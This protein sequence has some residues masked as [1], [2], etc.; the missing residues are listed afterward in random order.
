MALG[1]S[2]ASGT[3]SFAA[4]IGNNT[5]SYG[6]IGDYSVA[7]GK[8][9]KAS[10]T[11]SV[12]LGD[13][14]NAT[15]TYSSIVGYASTASANYASVFGGRS[16]TASAT[17]ATVIG[18]YANT[19]SGNGSIAT[20]FANTASGA[21]A[22][23]GGYGCT[24]SNA[25]AFAFG[26]TS[27]ASGANS[28]SIG[29][30]STAS[31]DKAITIGDNV[32][33]TATNQINLG[34]TADTVR[35][36]EGYTLPTA[37]GSANQVLQTNGSGALSFAD[38]GGGGFDSDIT[39]DGKT[40]NYTIVAGDAGKIISHSSNDVTFTFTAAATLGAGWHCWVKNR[41]GAADVTT[42]DFN[43]SE[44]LDG[45][46]NGKLFTGESIHVYCDGSNFHSVDRTI[47]WAGNTATDYYAQP[48][49][50]GGG[51]IAAGLQ[52]VSGGDDSIAIG[53]SSTANSSYSTAIGYGSY[54]S[55]TRAMA[56]G[57]SRTGG[58]DSLSA[59]IGTNSSSYGA[60]GTGAIAMGYQAKATTQNSIA[61]GA[62]TQASGFDNSICIGWQSTATSSRGAAVIGGR[63]NNSTG[64]YSTVLGGQGNT[65]SGD[66]S[67][68]MGDGSTASHNNSVSI[69]DSVQSTAVNQIN[70][71]GT[72]DTV[73]ISE[74]YTL[75]TA[76]GSANQVLT[77]NGSGVVS[78]AA[79]GGGA[80]LYAANESSPSAQPSATG[81]N[82]V[83]IGD[84]SVS[85][86]AD[87]LAFGDGATA[88][89]TRSTAIG[90]NATSSSINST[91][92]GPNATSSNFYTV[93]IGSPSNGTGSVATG[94]F[95]AIAI[96][97]YA[98]GTD[99]LA[100]AIGN[101]TSSYGATGANTVSL[102]KTAKSTATGAFSGGYGATAGGLYAAALGFYATANGYGSTALGVESK[103]PK[104]YSFSS[105]K[106]S[107]TEV[108]GSRV[109]GAGIFAAQG[110]QQSGLYLLAASTTD[111][112][113][114]VLTA[115]QATAAQDTQLAVKSNQVITFHGTVV[116]TQ[117]GVQSVAGWE[118]K[119]LLQNDGG[120]TT[121]VNS[122]ITVLNNASNWG[123]AL[124]ANDTLDCMAITVTGEASHNIRWLA[125]IN[126]SEVTYA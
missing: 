75:P 55:G 83:A 72:A 63:A 11:G 76:D 3:V 43:G 96:N 58:T 12:A 88:S 95:S 42:F 8:L 66:H 74:T 16:N 49:A 45:L 90:Y 67:V 114:T 94:A 47:M 106:H 52:A 23:A 111:A 116:A 110:D 17:Y 115:N 89:S 35:I 14:V 113:A 10:G 87:S 31:H 51:S 98:S 97:G 80:D 107:Q 73:R 5:S 32:Q 25:S 38:A 85:S 121:L 7:I 44:K 26:N 15:A 108:E 2:R 120:T 101:N 4:A 18:G 56:L 104:D 93:A 103:A 112:T 60:T 125:S 70:L 119:G 61:I 54:A 123:L 34:G 36:S 28:V 105:G 24:A 109:H 92:I 71:G 122:A 1:S 68:A 13:N 21:Y 29:H 30:T 40:A 6:A 37:D 118:I 46:G 124:T 9:A 62:E 22:L 33:S 64:D 81:V 39:I 41:A 117:N 19:S 79:A 57:W 84:S 59:Q 99:S 78:F 126:T 48:Q 53:F 82:A 69:G 77:T 65:A 27:V 102:G 50:S 91:A 20:G 86:G 100:G